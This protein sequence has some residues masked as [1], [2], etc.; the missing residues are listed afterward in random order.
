MLLVLTLYKAVEFWRISS[1]FKGFNL[2]KVLV[3]DQVMYFAW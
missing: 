3:V 2:V 1:G